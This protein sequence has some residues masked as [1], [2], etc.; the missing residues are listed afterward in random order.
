MAEIVLN[1]YIADG[2]FQPGT[3][4]VFFN[5]TVGA[6]PPTLAEL[7]AWLDAGDRTARI[8]PDYYP[9][10]YTAIDEL[11][12]FDSE[13]EG[14]EKMGVW[15]DPDFRVSQIT[16]ADAVTVK[17]VQW[18]PVPIRHRFGAGATLDGANG[19]IRV[20]KTYEPVEGTLFVLILDGSRPLGIHYY[21]VSS[22]PDGAIELDRE[23][24]LALP[25]RYTV[26]SA[27]GKAS[28]LNIL[29]F[30]LQTT[31]EDNDGT[32]DIIDE[33]YAGVV[34]PEADV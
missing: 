9:I 31:D 12:G 3:G 1:D 28:N 7:K 21:R 10:G 11:P 30:H 32:P 5:D 29:G 2:V 34:D 4:G 6:E 15:E 19:I 24:F 14:G 13:T 25:I 26:L 23:A 27:P 18:T 22:A 33:D 8:S 16:T 20:P 17:P